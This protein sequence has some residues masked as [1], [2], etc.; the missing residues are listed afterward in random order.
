MAIPPRIAPL[1]KNYDTAIMDV[2]RSSELIVL[3]VLTRGTLE[4]IDLLFDLYG[5]EKIKKIFRNN[6]YGLRT[7]PAPTVSLW[8][9]L[10]LNEEER[11]EYLQWRQNPYQRW[12]PRRIPGL[13]N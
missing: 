1:F 3:T 7:L 10:F 6:Y 13:M 8:G 12:A 11:K 9:L 2:E 4:Q 5:S